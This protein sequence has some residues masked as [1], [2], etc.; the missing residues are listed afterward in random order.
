M[1]AGLWQLNL[2]F[3]TQLQPELCGLRHHPFTAEPLQPEGTQHLPSQ[4]HL[5]SQKHRSS[6]PPKPVMVLQAI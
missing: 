4:Q 2:S 3:L 1:V 6:N 5:G